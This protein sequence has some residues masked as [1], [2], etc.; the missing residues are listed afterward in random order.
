ME[1]K[2]II[3][4]PVIDHQ[5]EFKDEPK[6]KNGV[7][8][9]I[10][11]IILVI[12]ITVS[13]LL[14]SMWGKFDVVYNLLATANFTWLLITLLVM[15]VSVLLRAFILFIFA[16]LY[17]N[18]YYF[19]Q[20]LAV[21]Q[22]GNFYSAVTP[23]ASGGQVMEAY[24]FQKQGLEVSNA[25][26]MLAMYSIVYQ[27]VL[28]LFGVIS[29]IVKFDFL[30]TIGYITIS[31]G[32]AELKVSVWILTI[33][34]FLLNVSVTLL[35]FLMAYW[36]GFH[37]F[38]MGPIISLCYKLHIIRNPEE[39][40]EN[41]KIQ[42]EN[43]KMEL[44]R[45]LTN[46]PFTILVTVIFILFF[47][48]R[49]SLPYFTGKVLNN[50]SMQA[51]IW[52]AV[53]LSNYHQMVTGLIPLPGSAGIS[54]YFFIQLFVNSHDP[55]LG[56][57]YISKA[58]A[59]ETAEASSALGSAALLIWRTISFSLPLLIAGFVTAFYRT[60][61]KHSMR[62]SDREV[63]ENRKTMLEMRR[64]TMLE[65][66]TQLQEMIHTNTLNREAISK[67]TNVVHKKDEKIRDPMRENDK[68]RT[69]NISTDE[70]DDE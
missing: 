29:F 44:R 27:I 15:F 4:E 36:R 30:N 34:G 49:F 66:Q 69:I 40:R 61:G 1:E 20:A 8:K 59:K 22:I 58:T 45:L 70:D 48:I 65:R 21:E 31:I 67:R 64:E 37:N 26:S 50:E 13:A 16:R 41:L 63:Y 5:K 56:F 12:V 52:D 54:E 23:G 42:I 46:V 35:I 3:T 33:I 18:E 25:V 17:S 39:T 57:Y 7:V 55:E 6:K 53:F 24:T 11:Y 62:F 19:H 51:N 28:T 43:F 68:I 47:F 32:A 38:M 9:Y 14:I 60:R 10:I 2:E